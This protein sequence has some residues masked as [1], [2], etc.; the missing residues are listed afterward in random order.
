VLPVSPPEVRIV[1]LA[2]QPAWA[3]VLADAFEREWPA[4]TS[5]VS[6]AR[7]EQCFACARP[8]ALP[9]AFAAVAGVVAIGTISLQ[10]AFD[11]EPMPESPW[12][13]GLL[14]LPAWRGR[15]VDRRLILAAENAAREMGFE[16]VYAATA[17]IETLARRRGWEVFRRIDHDGQPMAWMR[18]RLQPAAN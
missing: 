18:K 5:Q 2:G 11:E 8:G 3:G 10:A 1:S 15:G 7:V 9:Q 6:R 17:V 14:V 12:I 13:R 4:W 16:S